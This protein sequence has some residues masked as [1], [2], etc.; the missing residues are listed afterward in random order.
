MIHDWLKI[1]LLKLKWSTIHWIPLISFS[2]ALE[3]PTTFDL[4]G[5]AHFSLL[6]LVQKLHKHT[7]CNLIQKHFSLYKIGGQNLYKNKGATHANQYPLSNFS[8]L[9]NKANASNSQHKCQ[10]ISTK[11]ITLVKWLYLRSSNETLQWLDHE[12]SHQATNKK[13]K[14]NHQLLI[15]RK[16]KYSIR[17]EA[18]NK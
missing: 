5:I 8:L 2:S 3:M 11:T 10:T 6:P 16:S 14:R 15:S 17:Y 9:T 4:K 7:I 13:S 1:I 12:I 18:K